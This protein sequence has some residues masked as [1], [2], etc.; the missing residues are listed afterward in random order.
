LKPQNAAQIP[1]PKVL[2]S[3]HKFPSLRL[4][5]MKDRD[6]KNR[7]HHVNQRILPA[8]ITFAGRTLHHRLRCSLQKKLNQAKEDQREGKF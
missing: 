2:K 8:S 5:N 3:P 7:F 1:Q 6:V 4:W